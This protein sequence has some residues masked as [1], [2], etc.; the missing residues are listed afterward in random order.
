VASI[1]LGASARADAAPPCIARVTLSST[2]AHVGEQI[3]HRLRLLRRTDVSATAWLEAPGF[4]GFRVEMLPGGF[5]GARETVGG[6]HYVVYQE[7]RALFALEAGR[8]EIT[9]AQIECRLHA[10]GAFRGESVAVAVPGVAI[11]VTALPDPPAGFAG[12]VGPLAADLQ[13]EPSAVALGGSVRVVAM[14][15]GE[16]NLWDA[17]PPFAATGPPGGAEIFSEPP[18]LDLAP[19]PRLLLRRTFVYDVVP[20]R[21]GPLVLGPWIVPYFDLA[22]GRYLEARSAART[23]QVA[24]APVPGATL[25]APPPPAPAAAAPDPASAARRRALVLLALVV[26]GVGVGLLVRR[27]RR[28]VATPDPVRD[29][30]AAADAAARAGEPGG[31]ARALALA[32]RLA[33]ERR[34]GSQPGAAGATGA[35]H[36]SAPH[37]SA[38]EEL[39]ARAAGDAAAHDAAQLLLALERARFAPGA[40][41]PDLGRVRQAIE[42]LAGSAARSWLRGDAAGRGLSSG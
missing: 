39:A 26:G 41:A 35:A 10:V 21:P 6:R 20:R 19:G 28:R 14:L 15:V 33:L 17:E 22:S 34:L 18:R 13:V 42:G 7:R 12:V 32:L 24:D 4:R 5:E 16:G 3:E 29:A 23:V 11:D 9:P 37:A 1:A 2:R 38:A 27:R 30:L 31:Q 36:A 8:L 40:V 25:P